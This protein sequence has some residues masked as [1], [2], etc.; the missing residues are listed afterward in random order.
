MGIIGTAGHLNFRG[1]CGGGF[2][3]IDALSEMVNIGTLS[4]FI[5]VA[6]SIIVL[7]K[8][9]PHIPRKFKC[10]VVILIALSVNYFYNLYTLYV[11]F[12]Q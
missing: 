7:R 9:A 12:P 4:A 6:I 2:V 11:C 5:L 1:I 10:P 8:T 3:S